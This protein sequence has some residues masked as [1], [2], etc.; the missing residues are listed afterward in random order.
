MRSDPFLTGL[1]ADALRD[2]NGWE[3]GDD[4]QHGPAEHVAA[5][6]EQRLGAEH[7]VI[8]SEDRWTVEHSLACRISGEM[9]ECRYHAAVA[10]IAD[11]YEYEPDQ[12]GRWQIT[13][14]DEEGLPSLLRVGGD[15]EVRDG[16]E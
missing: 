14:I 5:A 11:D 16:T 13:N 7:Y 4:D 2:Y 1:I 8:F 9:A 3:P 10:E 15:E 6:L 12:W